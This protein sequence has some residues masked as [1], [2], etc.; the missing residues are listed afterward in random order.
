MANRDSTTNLQIAAE[1]T[2][3]A[4]KSA[5]IA[6]E[7]RRDSAAMK[8]IAILTMLYLPA[9]FVC[10]LFGT[11]F[12]ALSTNGPGIPV[13]VVSDLWWMYP[14]TA[15]PLTLLNLVVWRVWLRWRRNR[16]NGRPS[17]QGEKEDIV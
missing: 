17:V 12:F 6:Y 16:S 13:F 7:T 5:S 15:V 10:S 2:Q 11:N 14:A 4:K 3:I 9:T 8:T 1:S